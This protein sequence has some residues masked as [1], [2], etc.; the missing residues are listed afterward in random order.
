MSG[1]ILSYVLFLTNFKLCFNFIR[2]SFFRVASDSLFHKAI[3]RNMCYFGL[4]FFCYL[5]PKLDLSVTSQHYIPF[6][7][8]KVVFIFTFDIHEAK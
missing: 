4:F 3:A 7:F 1:N 6:L 8:F 5:F 2:V